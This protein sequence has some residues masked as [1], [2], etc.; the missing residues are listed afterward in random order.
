VAGFIPASVIARHASAEAISVF[1]AIVPDKSGNYKIWGEW[2]PKCPKTKLN[3]LYMKV[4]RSEVA[5][6]LIDYLEHD[7]TLAELVDWAESDSIHP[8]YPFHQI[9]FINY[10]KLSNAESI[11]T[12]YPFEGLDVAST[13]RIFF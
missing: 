9:H 1:W 11:H 13:E 3:S 2:L 4:T 5:E 8:H 12:L 10:P 7:I 6:K